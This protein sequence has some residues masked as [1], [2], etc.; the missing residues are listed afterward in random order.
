MDN[1]SRQIVRQSEEHFTILYGI[2][3]EIRSKDYLYTTET[4]PLKELCV[5]QLVSMEDAM[6]FYHNDW[7]SLMLKDR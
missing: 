7:D 6:L 4:A 2:Q 5:D 3:S 1:V